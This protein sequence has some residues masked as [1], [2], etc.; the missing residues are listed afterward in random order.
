MPYSVNELKT[1]YNHISISE[2]PPE[3]KNAIEKLKTEKA[4]DAVDLIRMMLILT[5]IGGDNQLAEK[6]NASQYKSLSLCFS[7][8]KDWAKKRAIIGCAAIDHEEVLSEA[9]HYYVDVED[10]APPVPKQKAALSKS[11]NAPSLFEAKTASQP[12]PGLP[13][14]SAIHK[15]QHTTNNTSQKASEENRLISLF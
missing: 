2:A 9:I 10:A 1:E 13:K 3:V 4:E 6:I 15:K 7:H 12:L 14:A 11:N 8:I 5:L